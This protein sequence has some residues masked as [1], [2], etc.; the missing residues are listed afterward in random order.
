LEFRKIKKNSKSIMA[1]KIVTAFLLLTVFAQSITESPWEG[2]YYFNLE[3][4][5]QSCDGRWFKCPVDKSPI[6]ITRQGNT[7]Q[8]ESAF[9]QQITSLQITDEG[10][11]VGTGKNAPRI[12]K[13]RLGILLHPTGG[14]AVYAYRDSNFK[15]YQG[16]WSGEY[17]TQPCYSTLVCCPVGVV[18]IK[19]LS[20]DKKGLELSGAGSDLCP[21]KSFNLAIEAGSLDSDS[22][23]GKN[24]VDKKDPISYT[25]NRF[26]SVIVVNIRAL[27]IKLYE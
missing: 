10:T 5:K 13:G 4:S 6:R 12:G 11:A 17:K 27:S 26:T 14:M 25:V 21:N 9:F 15:S 19:E 20:G 8:V 22:F 18:T 23:Q 7:I 3:K 24:A 2:T 1:L 16:T